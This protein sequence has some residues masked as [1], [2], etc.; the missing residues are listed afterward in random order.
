[1][2]ASGLEQHVREIARY[3]HSGQLKNY[4]MLMASGKEA[5]LGMEKF[6]GRDQS[7]QCVLSIRHR[8]RVMPTL[9]SQAIANGMGQAAVLVL[10]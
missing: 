7:E 5:V 10:K 1:M 2:D 9:I 8:K 4:A 3:V 6:A